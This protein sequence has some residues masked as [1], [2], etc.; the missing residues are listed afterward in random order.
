MF[1]LSGRDRL[2]K[3]LSV[4][5]LATFGAIALSGAAEGAVTPLHRTTASPTSILS[6]FERAWADVRAY[7]ATITLFEKQDSRMQS[8]LVP[9]SRTVFYAAIGS[10]D[11]YCS[12]LT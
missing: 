7:T 8:E 11:S 12:G 4:S 2:L 9:I 1:S 5:L 3:V 6:A 10:D